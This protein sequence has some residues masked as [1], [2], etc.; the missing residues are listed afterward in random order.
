MKKNLK[1]RRE[2]LGSA[3]AGLGMINLTPLVM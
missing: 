3:F 2:F 1:T